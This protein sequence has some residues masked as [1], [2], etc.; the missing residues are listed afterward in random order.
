GSVSAR[1][2]GDR[3]RLRYNNIEAE[4]TADKRRV[5][6]REKNFDL[7]ANFILE[8]SRGFVPLTGLSGLLSR[9]VGNPVSFNPV[10]R[11]LFV[12]DIAIHF[13]AQVT[14]TTPQKLIMNFSAPVNPAIGT[15]PGKLKMTFS[16][17]PV[18]SPGS[19]T[20]TFASSMIPSA[21]YLESNGEAEL[22]IT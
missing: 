4:F 6:V 3:W 12:G 7:P 22:V 19:S 18:V 10:S 1:L 2:N 13:T 16:H 20:L 9:I 14:S 21:T 8:G 5:R 11:R 15:E 17:D